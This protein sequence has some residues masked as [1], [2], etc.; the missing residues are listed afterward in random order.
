MATRRHVLLGM[1]W[2]NV[3]A[4]DATARDI[5]IELELELELSVFVWN[6]YT[7]FDAS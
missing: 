2:E 1:Q 7:S 4:N 3:T 6:S 5:E